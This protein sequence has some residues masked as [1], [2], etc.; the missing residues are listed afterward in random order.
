MRSPNPC[1]GSATIAAPDTAMPEI[2]FITRARLVAR[3]HGGRRR[4]YQLLHE[5][6][7]H[8]TPPH[9]NVVSLQ[10]WHAAAGRNSPTQRAAAALRRR[11]R[12][13]LTTVI[14][15]GIDFDGFAPPAFVAHVAARLDAR[16]GTRLVVVDDARLA[17]IIE[18]ARARRLPCIL[19]PHNFESL[20]ALPDPC[21]PTRRRAHLLDFASELEALQKAAARVM[22]SDVE[23]AFLSALGIAASVHPYRPVGDLAEPLLRIR[24]ERSAA[25]PDPSLFVMLGSAMHESTFRSMRRLVDQW[26]LRPLPAG[27]RIVVAGAGTERFG[28]LDIAGV[29]VRGWV[30]PE[31]LHALLVAARAVLIPQDHGFGAVTRAAD[32]ACAGVPVVASQHIAHA[33]DLPPGVRTAGSDWGEWLKQLHATPHT[34]SNT[35]QEYEAWE[36]TQPRALIERCDDF[37]RSPIDSRSDSRS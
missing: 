31:L 1:S 9:V 15:T 11:A 13:P 19:C 16:P 23:A 27:M 18:L 28:R 37:L 8:F 12:N 14:D 6:Q 17:P 2:L 29:D 36:R 5:L 10:E 25:P 32:M 4:T 26:R 30:E 35:E 20:D 24:R 7:E 34:V 21:S 22:I 3:G 33:L